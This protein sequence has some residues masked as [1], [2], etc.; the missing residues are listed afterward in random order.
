MFK[1]EIKCTSEHLVSK[2]KKRKIG[3]QLASEKPK[4]DKEVLKKLLAQ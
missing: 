4:L 2:K 1:K 3:E